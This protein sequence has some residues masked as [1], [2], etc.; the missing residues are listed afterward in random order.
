MDNKVTRVLARSLPDSTADTLVYTAGIYYTLVTHIVVSNLTDAAA[1]YTIYLDRDGSGVYN[2][3]NT[4]VKAKS[5]GGNSWECLD[6][7]LP[8]SRGAKL[9]VKVGTASA[10]NFHIIGWDN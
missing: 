10:L 3:A 7:P 1:V 9:A 8:L 4:L 6:I 2:D 5:L